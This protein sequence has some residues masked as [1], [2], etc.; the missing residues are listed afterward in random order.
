MICEEQHAVV[1][2]YQ[3]WIQCETC[4]RW[5]HQYCDGILNAELA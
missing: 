2:D 3:E 5:V 4:E 1:A